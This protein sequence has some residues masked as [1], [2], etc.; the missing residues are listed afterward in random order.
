MFKGVSVE[1]AARLVLAID[2]PASSGKSSVA[3]GVARELDFE[4]IDT[5]AMYRAI[6]WAVL[7]AGIDL[8]DHEAIADCAARVAPALVWSVDPVRPSMRVGEVDVT[9]AIREPDVTAAVSAVSA[10]PAT[11]A[12]LV[13]RQRAAVSQAVEQDRGVVMEGRDIGTVVLPHADLK[14]WLYAEPSVRAAR[15][16][17]EDL[18]AGRVSME[19]VEEMAAELAR[20]D[21][22]D[23]TRLDSPTRQA[24][25]AIA[26][27]AT[28]LTLPEV[29]STV[30][31]LIDERFNDLRPNAETADLKDL[32]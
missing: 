6:T 18:A 28:Q 9:S 14:V 25:D 16:V 27:D 24:D 10:V 29:I 15:R 4:Y 1:H 20:R 8:N 21:H 17:A 26:V 5:G 23:S 3:K 7:Q 11:R 22:A 2:G 30:I 31:A 13:E 32:T 12:A 19:S